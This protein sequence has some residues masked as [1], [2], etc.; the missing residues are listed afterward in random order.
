MTEEPTPM[1]VEILIDLLING[2]NNPANISDNIDRSRPGVSD[3]LK[4]MSESGWV[5][6]KGSGVWTLTP[7]GISL[8]QSSLSAEFD[9]FR[10]SD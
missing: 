5:A 10:L 8:A 4:D 3:R 6:S 2:D 9:S 1:G 7:A